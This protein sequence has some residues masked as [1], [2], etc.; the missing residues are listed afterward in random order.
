MIE[1]DKGSYTPQV[2]HLYGFQNRGVFLKYNQLKQLTCINN[3]SVLAS[4]DNNMDKEKLF[5]IQ[6][7]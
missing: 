3:I 5:F 6:Q 1:F 4:L 2:T 7:D